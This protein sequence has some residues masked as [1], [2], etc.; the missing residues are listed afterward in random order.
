[1]IAGMGETDVS[2]TGQPPVD[3][4]LILRGAGL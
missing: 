4:T 3:T 2:Q 1:L